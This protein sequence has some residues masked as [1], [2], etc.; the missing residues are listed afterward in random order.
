MKKGFTLVELLGVITV[1]AIIGLIA[2]PVVNKS[3]KDSK[4]RA[5]E[6]EVKEIEKAAKSWAAEHIE[7]IGN[8]NCSGSAVKVVTIEELKQENY[9]PSDAKNPKSGELLTGQVS[10]IYDCEYNSYEYVY[11]E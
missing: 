2:I 8:I 6:A 10:I 4:E 7:E 5:Y 11:E 9:L 3:I 1:L